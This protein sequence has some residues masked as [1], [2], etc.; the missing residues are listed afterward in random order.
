M[1]LRWPDLNYQNGEGVVFD[2][3]EDTIVADAVAPEACE[4]VGEWFTEGFS[5]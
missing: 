5:G 1:V 4:I 2:L 3:A